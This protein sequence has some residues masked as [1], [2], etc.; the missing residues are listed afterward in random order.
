MASWAHLNEEGMKQF[1]D[2]FPDGTVPIRSI[3]PAQAILSNVQPGDGDKEQAVYVVNIHELKP[4]DLDKLVQKIA[5]K[6]KAPLEEVRKGI[7]GTEGVVLRTTLTTGAGTDDLSW[8]DPDELNDED[9]DIGED[10]DEED[11]DW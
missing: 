6:F 10:D 2:I 4:K 11:E 3:L 9:E 1:G 8:F 5:S 7:T